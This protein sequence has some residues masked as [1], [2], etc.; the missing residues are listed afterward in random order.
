MVTHLDKIKKENKE[1][2]KMSKGHVLKEEGR[3]K[4]PTLIKLDGRE[5]RKKEEKKKREKKRNKKKE[6]AKRENGKSFS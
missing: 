1:R 6:W 3:R 5:R 2:K 4:I